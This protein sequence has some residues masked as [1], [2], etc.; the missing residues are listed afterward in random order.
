MSEPL[1]RLPGDVE[2][3]PRPGPVERL[4]ADQARTLRQKTAISRGQ[5]PLTYLGA[6]RHPDTLSE[7]YARGD[8]RGRPLTCGTCRFRELHGAGNRTVA[9]CIWPP[10][11]MAAPRFTSSASSDV[12]A[13]WPACTGHEAKP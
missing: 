12:R 7:V 1:F 10:G 8:A 9:K 4:S 5:H 2:E 13:W 6:V 11:T 3:Q